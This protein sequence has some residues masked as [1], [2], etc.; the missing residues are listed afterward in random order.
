MEI[1]R[2]IL[3]AYE[4]ELFSLI[5]ATSWP[6]LIEC[7]IS[8]AFILFVLLITLGIPLAFFVLMFIAPFL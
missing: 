5:G 2:I 4:Q 6:D 3:E 7:F 8:Y 1:I